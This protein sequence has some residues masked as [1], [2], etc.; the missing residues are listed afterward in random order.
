MMV[1]GRLGAL[2]GLPTH[3]QAPRIILSFPSPIEQSNVLLLKCLILIHATCNYRNTVGFPRTKTAL[4][5]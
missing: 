3:A 5:L 1:V 4:C 2:C